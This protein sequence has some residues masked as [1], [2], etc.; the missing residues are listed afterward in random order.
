MSSNE[1]EQVAFQYHGNIYYH[2]FKH[3]YPGNELY[4]WYGEQYA[5]ELG[6]TTKIP[7]AG[8]GVFATQFIPCRFTFGPYKGRRVL[9][10]ELTEGEDTS[11]MW[12]VL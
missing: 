2:S 1:D 3:I 6:I 5:K 4:V 11:Y 10:E 7:N 12:E 8:L 9:K